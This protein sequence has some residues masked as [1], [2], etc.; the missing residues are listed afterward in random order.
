MGVPGWHPQCN[1]VDTEARYRMQRAVRVEREALQAV[2]C[3]EIFEWHGEPRCALEAQT[4]RRAKLADVARHGSRDEEIHGHKETHCE[5]DVGCYSGT[6]TSRKRNVHS[7]VR[8]ISTWNSRDH[9]SSTT[10]R[11]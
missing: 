2:S 5:A 4:P 11:M 1:A 6:I 8:S 9:T 10:A 3:C 7:G